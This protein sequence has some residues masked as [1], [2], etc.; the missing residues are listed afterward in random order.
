MHIK[1]GAMHI[2]HGRKAWRPPRILGGHCV[3]VRV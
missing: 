1:H 2:K 3:M